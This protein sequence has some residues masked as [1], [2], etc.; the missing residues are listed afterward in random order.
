MPEPMLCLVCNQ[1]AGAG[2]APAAPAATDAPAAAA[3][4][5]RAP[6]QQVRWCLATNHP[7]RC[8]RM[9]V[10]AGSQTAIFHLQIHCSQ[11]R[12]CPFT[13]RSRYFQL[14]MRPQRRLPLHP[15][16]LPMR[17]WNR[18]LPRRRPPP[19]RGP[20]GRAPRSARRRRA[21][22]GWATWSHGTTSPTPTPT[23][24]SSTMSQVCMA[25]MCLAGLPWKC[26]M[27]Q[28][29]SP[30][31]LICHLHLGVVVYI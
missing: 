14:A 9:F 6:P 22:C 13:C 24:T 21:C 31:P 8:R 3:A 20:A 17:P 7:P 27:V 5:P 15:L 23:K 28:E 19:P 18:L 25:G 2:G 1:G 10:S 26:L 11:N 12:C 30:T 16:P 29:P 4:P